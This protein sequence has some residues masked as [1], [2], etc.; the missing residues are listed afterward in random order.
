MFRRPAHKA[1]V[2]RKVMN[3]RTVPR[4]TVKTAVRRPVHKKTAARTTV[5]VTTREITEAMSVTVRPVLRSVPTETTITTIID[6]TIITITATIA[7]TATITIITIITA[8]IIT[9]AEIAAATVTIPNLALRFPSPRQQLLPVR[10]ILP[11]IRPM[12]RIT[13]RIWTIRSA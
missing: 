1:P 10:A 12:D 4:K 2:I 13:V 11:R 7:I 9:I 8:I 5:P 3:R 6:T